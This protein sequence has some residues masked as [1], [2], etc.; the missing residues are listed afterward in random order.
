MYFFQV[1]KWCILYTYSI[2]Q[3]VSIRINFWQFSKRFI[4]NKTNFMSILKRRIKWTDL[5]SIKLTANYLC[6]VMGKKRNKITDLKKLADVFFIFCYLLF[7][8]Y[9]GRLLV[10]QARSASSI[11]PL[12]YLKSQHLFDQKSQRDSLL[13]EKGRDTHRKIWI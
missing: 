5:Q 10:E 7:G 13:Y 3:A 2:Q 11:C 9:N 6:H 4:T 8:I 1:I 12:I